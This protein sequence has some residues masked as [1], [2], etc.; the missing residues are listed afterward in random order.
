MTIRRDFTDAYKGGNMRSAVL[1]SLAAT[2][3]A[4]ALALGASAASIASASTSQPAKAGGTLQVEVVASQW[5]GLD[6]ATDTQDTADA[7]YLNEIYGQLFEMNANNVVIPDQATTWKLTNHNSTLV[8]NLR[9]GL[10]F[11]NGDPMTAAIVAWS[12]NRDT[13]PSFGN[14]GLSN[15]PLTAAGCSGSGLTVTCPLKE[16]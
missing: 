9:K 16:P 6:S 7:A 2:A 13:T 11:S 10:V 14:I 1:R 3:V 8:F 5:P 15:L 12:I 4:S